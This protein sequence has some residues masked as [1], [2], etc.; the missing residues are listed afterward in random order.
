MARFKKGILLSQR[1]FILDLLLKDMMLEYM[2]IDSLMNVK[3]KLLPCQGELLEDVGRYRRLVEKLN[4]LTVT[5]SNITFI[6]N[7]MSQ[8]LSALKYPL[9][10]GNKNFEV[11]EGR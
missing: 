11:S 9:E 5:R 10:G 7:V 3:R 4:Y 2:S 8:F 1:K 6:V